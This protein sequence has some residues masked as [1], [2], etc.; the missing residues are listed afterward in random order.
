MICSLESLLMLLNLT[1]TLTDTLLRIQTKREWASWFKERK[2][3][4]S[5]FFPLKSL[6][7][8]VIPKNVSVNKAPLIKPSLHFRNDKPLLLPAATASCLGQVVVE[9]FLLDQKYS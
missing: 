7:V 2:K 8:R 3:H 1:G 6:N 5:H 4:L 9:F